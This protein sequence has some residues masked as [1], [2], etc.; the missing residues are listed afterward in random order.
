MASTGSRAT[1][2]CAAILG[3][4]GAFAAWFDAQG[5]Q[6]EWR[7][8][9]ARVRITPE[10]PMPLCGYGPRVSRGVLDEL[11]AKAMAIEAAGGQ[12][13]VLVTADLL[14]FRA[15][16]AEAICRR[17]MAK[18][19]LLRHQVLL[20]ASHTHSG[21]IVGMT[22]DLDS[23]EVSQADRARVEAYTLKL[24]QQLT[25]LAAQALAGVQPARLSWGVGKADFVMNRRLVTKDGVVMAPNPQGR[26]DRNVPVLR[27]EA[28]DGRMRAVVF[29]C[30]C[31]NVTLDGENRKI[32]G[33]YAGVAQHEI[34]SRAP[35]VQAMFLAGCGGD[36]NSHP[37]G[38]SEQEQWVRRHGESLA[39]EVCR[40]AVGQLRPVRGPLRLELTWTDLPLEHSLSRERLAELARRSAWHARNVQAML[41][42]MDRGEPLP[43]HYRAPFALWQFGDDLT[44]VGLP[45]EAVSG[46]VPLIEDALEPQRLWIAAY[47]NELFGYLPTKN[48]LAEGG[49]ESMCLTLD[50][51]FFSAEVEKVVVAA[52]RQMAQP[53]HPVIHQ[54]KVPVPMR[55]GVKLA[56]EI[57]RPDAPGKFPVLMLHR[58]FREGADRAE[59]FAKRGYA[60]ALVDCR[61]RYDS[62]GT[63]VPY[64]N[65]PQ[66]GYDAQQWLGTQPWSTARSARSASPTTA[67]RSPWPPRWPART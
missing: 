7:I 33:D 46:Y 18:T 2:V 3:L 65:D 27:V 23:F 32:S 16:V 24:E 11:D 42:K 22:K 14:F 59:F 38:G 55:D 40:V 20:N 8:G 1:C 50:T 49:H 25:D 66:D 36:A 31:H 26:I 29:G 10:G 48:V 13:A 5:D 4:L 62:E 61:G 39:A 57:F 34:E 37:R 58:Y 6:P 28:A 43:T 44:L 19:G 41:Q 56:A 51:G 30:A 54:T 12:R 64:V 17:I 15:P 45:G 60:V 21:P 53:T 35:G 63:W 52:V 9:L 47:C 67:S